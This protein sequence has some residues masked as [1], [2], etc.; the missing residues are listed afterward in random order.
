M[1]TP[2]ISKSD[3]EG[4]LAEINSVISQTQKAIAAG[5]AAPLLILWGLIWVIGYSI[6]HFSPRSAGAA[7]MVLVFI[8]SASSWWAGVKIQ[9][10]VKSPNDWKIGVFWLVLFGYAF[11]WLVLLAP[12]GLPRGEEWMTRHPFNSKQIGAFFATIPMFAYV[13][14]GLWLGRFFVWLGLLVT[15]LTFVGYFLFNE[16]FHLWMAITGG[17]SLILAGVYVR[18]F[19]R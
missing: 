6:T 3:A 10:P 13:V 4:A 8:G 18:K 17:G 16:Y 7:W 9:S 19:W 5:P 2:T 12:A 15:A 14:G 11:A 1:T